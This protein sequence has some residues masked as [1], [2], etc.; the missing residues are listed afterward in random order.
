MFIMSLLD[1]V[2]PK[3]K[4]SDHKVRLEAIEK[5]IDKSILHRIAKYDMNTDVRIAAIE[6]VPTIL[7]LCLSTCKLQ[8][9]HTQ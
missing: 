8:H 3:W 2:K 4:H 6:N 9:F 5:V 7:V 1:F